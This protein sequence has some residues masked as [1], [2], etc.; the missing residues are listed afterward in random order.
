[1]GPR[2]GLK[3]EG[4]IEPQWWSGEP[5]ENS[6]RPRPSE[7]RKTPLSKKTLLL[8]VLAHIQQFGSENISV[9]NA[10]F[11]IAFRF[12]FEKSGG[13]IAPASPMAARCLFGN[14]MIQ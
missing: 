2:S 4:L 11:A 3:V 10:I 13:A 9:E 7:G 1:M 12:I 5:S 14:G 6:F 8:Y